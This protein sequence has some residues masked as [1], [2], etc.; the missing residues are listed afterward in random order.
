M[1]H[2]AILLAYKGGEYSIY[3]SLQPFTTQITKD[4]KSNIVNATLTL[5]FT[6]GQGACHFPFVLQRW[7]ILH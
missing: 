1:E 7:A 5:I 2:A 3:D 4:A 6:M